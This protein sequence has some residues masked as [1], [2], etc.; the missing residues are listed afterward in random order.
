LA[1][2]ISTDGIIPKLNSG[3]AFQT[4]GDSA[5]PE[6]IGTWYFWQMGCTAMVT[7]LVYG[8][9]STSTSSRVIRRSAASAPVAGSLWSSP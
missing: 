1:T 2:D 5:E 8:P 4:F 3:F 6:I 7:P 9:S